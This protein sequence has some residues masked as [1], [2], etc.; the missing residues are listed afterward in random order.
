VGLF[1]ILGDGNIGNDAS[2]EAV[3][4]YLARE[5]PD[6]VLDAMTTGA[7]R[8]SNVYGIDAVP[9]SGRHSERQ[10][11]WRPLALAVNLV[12]LVGQAVR[13]A[14]WVRR[15]DVII[16]PGMGV[17]EASLPLRPWETPYALF[18]LCASGRLF[19][20]KVA[21]VSVGADPIK[22]RA[23]RW[24]LNGAARSAFY[25]SYRDE[26][27]RAAMQQRGLDTTRDAVYPDLVFGLEPTSS[28]EPGD[29]ASVGLGVMAY[30]GSNDDDRADAEAIHA[31]YLAKM[32]R[33]VR[34]L[35]DDGRRVRLIIG[36]RCDAP[37]AQAL[38]ADV[39][40]YRPDLDPGVVVIE[41]VSSF[42]DVV[43]ALQ[44][45]GVVVASRFHNIICALKLA[46]PTISIEYAPK[47]SELMSEMGLSNYC[48]SA[49]TLAV[50]QLIAQI[51]EVDGQA[52]RLRPQIAQA[53]D[54]KVKL[55][56]EQFTQL[57]SV[58]FTRG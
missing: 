44:P 3:L 1:G 40:R 19:G 4:G 49:G 5:H 6:S 51:S 26:G 20:T 29:P 28:R 11:T 27:S 47:N 12:G 43:R 54:L 2:M 46:K 35:V 32:K 55:L 10:T 23:T 14:A 30:Y 42:D 31:A 53:R 13:T 48:H 34:W 17:L 33:F 45:V 15:H 41:S 36:D 56:D 57:S 58:L 18:L 50:D 8:L 24:L 7:D 9:L 38:L 22:K 25:R 37:V 39:E 16:V 52:D 21:L